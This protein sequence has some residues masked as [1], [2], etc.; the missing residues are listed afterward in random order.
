MPA[1]LPLAV[2]EHDP[3]AAPM[4]SRWWCWCT[5]P[6]TGRPVS[7]GSVRRLDDLHTVAY[8]R[9]GYQG[10]RD[11][12]PLNTTLDGHIDDLLAVIDGRTSV[13]VGHSYGG[14][15]ALGAALRP[16]GG[17][18][19]RRGGGLRATDAVAGPWA[20]SS[21][22]AAAMQADPASAVPT[23]SC[24]PPERRGGRALLPAH[25]RGRGLG[26]AV[27]RG[28]GGATGRRAG[29][30]GRAG[31]H[32]DRR[33]PLRRQRL[34][35]C[36]PP[37]ADGDR[38]APRHRAT[39]GWLAEHVPGAELVEIAG[40]S[41]G[42]HL[43]HPD[44]FA[45]MVRSA[46]ARAGYSVG[47]TMNMLVSGASGLIGTAL[48][49]R[50]QPGGPPVTRLVRNPTGPPGGTRPGPADLTWAPDRGQIDVA[51][52]DRAGTLS[53]ASSTW[54]GPASGTGVGRAAAS[55]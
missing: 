18:R 36:P 53:T 49:E 22:S 45:A 44:A 47:S 19:D 40:A 26:P 41:H 54:P 9:R 52:L 4:P 16:V 46:V 25:G 39:V 34:W 35:P 29:T 15:V 42:A 51:G 43:T 31:G 33:G 1:S 8:D 38:S 6:S 24:R 12:L 2:T 7:P 23:R 14:D 32:P 50:L 48:V 55:R 3:A 30:G 13:V 20:R 10:S 5:V 11:A 28:Q 37:S 17:R 21:T 27:R